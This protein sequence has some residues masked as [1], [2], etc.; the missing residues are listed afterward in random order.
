M[1]KKVDTVIEAARL[2]GESL[3][4]V[5]KIALDELSK[6]SVSNEPWTTVRDGLDKLLAR[7]SAPRPSLRP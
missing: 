4:H 6:R 5:R 2:V 1:G 7:G 3:S